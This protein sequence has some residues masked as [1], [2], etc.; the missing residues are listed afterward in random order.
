VNASLPSSPNNTPLLRVE[1]LELGFALKGT[2]AEASRHNTWLKALQGVSFKLHA[3]EVLGLVGESGSGK[4]LTSMAI[5]GLLPEKAKLLAG[6]VYLQGRHLN[7]LSQNELRPLRGAVM[8]LIPQDPMSALNPVYTVGSQMVEVLQAHK[9][10]LSTREAERQVLELL[11]RVQIPNAK[12]RLAQYPHE[13]SGGMRQ[14]V[15]IAMALSC[16][17]AL[18]IADEPTTALDVTVQAQILALLE[19]LRKEENMGLLLITHDLGVVAEACDRVAVMYGGQIV[20]ETDVNALFSKPRHPYTQGL[21]GSIPVAGQKRLQGI[22]GQPPTLPALQG[23]GCAFAP[24]CSKQQTACTQER[25]PWTPEADNA[26]FRCLF[27]L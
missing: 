13:F 22:A 26:G 12:S 18:L 20:E 24:R 3:G 21:L 16:K 25:I 19:Q 11:E 10:G 4:S 9:K 23:A 7:K 14:R 17:P 6:N 8:A 5:L 15:L 1:G 27:P 2:I